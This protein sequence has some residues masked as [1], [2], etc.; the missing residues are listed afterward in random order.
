MM[1]MMMMMMMAMMMM[2][3]IIII[4]IVI[5]IIIIKS[6]NCHADIYEMHVTALYF[7]SHK[8]YIKIKPENGLKQ[9]ETA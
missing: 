7:P 4:I 8:N 6:I 9:N 5:I 3:I 2:V 1:I